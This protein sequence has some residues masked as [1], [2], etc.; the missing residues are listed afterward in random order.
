MPEN[1][2]SHNKPNLFPVLEKGL[3]T[4]FELIIRSE[5]R[6]DEKNRLRNSL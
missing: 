6:R 5:E 2:A 3:L 4:G 1:L